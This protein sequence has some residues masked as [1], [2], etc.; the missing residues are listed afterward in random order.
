MEAYG[1]KM[2]D[3]NTK[4]AY[5]LIESEAVARLMNMCDKLARKK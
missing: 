5:W 2:V 4:T 1:F 3:E